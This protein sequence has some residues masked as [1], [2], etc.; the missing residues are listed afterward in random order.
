MGGFMRSNGDSTGI[1]ILALLAFFATMPIYSPNVGSLKQYIDSTLVMD[2][3]VRSM[4]AA[5]IVASLAM[6]IFALLR[7]HLASTQSRLRTALGC[8]LYLIGMLLFLGIAAGLIPQNYLVAVVAG[9]CLG[10]GLCTLAIAW[11]TRL[12]TYSLR[13]ALL[14][15]CV[16]CGS[17][18]AANW[19][20]S[21]LPAVPLTIIVLVLVVAASLYPVLSP[22]READADHPHPSETSPDDLPHL[23]AERPEN[24]ETTHPGAKEH[25]ALLDTMR[26]F[27]SVMLTPLVGLSMFAFFMGTSR[28]IVFNDINAEV[29]GNMVAG[30]M[31]APL[32]LLRLRH[33]FI[34]TLTS[35]VLPLAACL[36]LF[37]IVL[38][39]EL[40]MM[41][42]FVPLASYTLFCG[43]AQISLAVG[44]AS[45]KNREFPPALTWSFYLFMFTLCSAAGLIF[46]FAEAYSGTVFISPWLIALYCALLIINAIASLICYPAPMPEPAKGATPVAH[47]A[48]EHTLFEQRCDALADRYALSPREREIMA[49]IGR[50]HTATYITK[51]LIISE[52]TVYTHARNIYRKMGIG[53]KE[54]LIEMLTED[55]EK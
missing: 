23:V 42:S 54:S 26:R 15:M 37:A 9:V 5:T 52:S 51:T 39:Y 43:I 21:F 45:M 28:V 24:T 32:C 55:I 35:V 44:V 33:P 16:V 3:F 38:A 20:F 19:I 13:Q 10:P 47:D 27:A 11:G 40:D 36:M 50:G 48:D 46:G 29:I 14:L 49:Y 41:E 4:M 25:P 12:C 53:S 7:P 17:T 8:T 6:L 2:A 18:A 22:S 34:V 1:E 31:L 30:A